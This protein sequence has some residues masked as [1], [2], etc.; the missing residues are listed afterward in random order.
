VQLRVFAVAS[1]AGGNILKKQLFTKDICPAL[2][3]RPKKGILD[4]GR[5]T[6]VAKRR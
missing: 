4:G 6:A 2:G 5:V 1:D 3:Y